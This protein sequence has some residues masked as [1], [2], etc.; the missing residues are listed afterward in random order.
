MR[1]FEKT[2]ALDDL[3]MKNDIGG[4]FVIPVWSAISSSFLIMIKLKSV[5]KVIVAFILLKICEINA[6][7][8][9]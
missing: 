6:G 3:L 8:F 5:K 9:L 1:L 4:L 7:A 2:S